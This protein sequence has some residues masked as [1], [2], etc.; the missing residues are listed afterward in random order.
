MHRRAGILFDPAAEQIQQTKGKP[1]LIVAGLDS[2]TQKFGRFIHRPGDR[3][4]QC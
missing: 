4:G 3:I 1:C 2:G